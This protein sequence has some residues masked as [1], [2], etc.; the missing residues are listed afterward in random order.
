VWQI[1]FDITEPATAREDEKFGD[2]VVVSA[3]AGQ[4][5][6]SDI[7]RDFLIGLTDDWCSK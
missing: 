3:V 1:T 4:W 7:Q 6:V 5:I 2:Y